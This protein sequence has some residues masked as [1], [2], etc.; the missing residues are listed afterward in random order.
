[1]GEVK[2]ILQQS[3]NSCSSFRCW[4]HG[5]EVCSHF[6]T[7]P[8]K[9]RRLNPP[10]KIENFLTTEPIFQLQSIWTVIFQF[11][12]KDSSSICN[13]LASDPTWSFTYHHFFTH[14]TNLQNS[15]EQEGQHTNDD[16]QLPLLCGLNGCC[17]NIEALVRIHNLHHLNRP[18]WYFQQAAPSKRYQQKC[19]SNLMR[20]GKTKQLISKT[21]PWN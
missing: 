19:V 20:I 1:M 21:I 12:T 9:K 13:M 10:I 18:T 5:N 3:T 16:N 17:N 4:S 8:R 11:L 2:I 15:K 14:S 6:G 7:Y